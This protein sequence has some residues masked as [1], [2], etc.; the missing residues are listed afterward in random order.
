M[1]GRQEAMLAVFEEHPELTDWRA[2][3]GTTMLHLAAGRGE[4]LIIKWLIDHGKDVNARAQCVPHQRATF[5]DRSPRGCTPL[6]FAAIGR[7]SDEWLFNNDKFRPA[8]RALLERGA[9]LSPVSAAALG[10]WDY[11][12]KLSKEELEG[13]GVLEAAVKGDQPDTLRRLLDVGLDPDE[14]FQVGHMEEKAWSSGGPMFQAVV[15]K[16]IE[17]ARVLLERRADPNASVYGG[18]GSVPRLRQPQS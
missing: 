7:G 14:P 9:E 2:A 10:R 3:D 17:M 8:A 1:T 12:E 18:L 15:L 11:L 6:D 4:S 13:K 16:R 5:L